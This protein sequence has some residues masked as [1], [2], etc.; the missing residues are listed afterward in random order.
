[1][2][3]LPQR[4]CSPIYSKYSAGRL[5]VS[6]S[7]PASPVLRWY[8]RRVGG[9]GPG[10]TSYSADAA[11]VV[12]RNAL[13]AGPRF[14][15]H[16]PALPVCSAW[17]G[18]RPGFTGPTA[19]GCVPP[20]QPE[21]RDG[22][23]H[24]RDTRGHRRGGHPRRRARRRRARPDRRAARRRGVPGHASWLRGLARLAARVRDRLPG[25]DRGDRQLRRRPGP[26][27]GD[28]W[29]PGRGG[30][31]LGPAGPAQSGRARGAP[32]GRDGQVEAI[33]ALMVAK[34]TARSERTQ[35]I[36]QARAL[37][38]TGPDDLRTRFS[39]HTPAGLVADL[40]ARAR[41][42]RAVPRQPA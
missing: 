12:L 26:A 38:L 15:W 4:T 10:L 27:H 23:D 17:P 9:L 1:M 33:R 40:A 22:I 20:L 8:G 6:A 7:G 31:P 37:V 28:G 24:R 25:R 5:W 39:R 3:V 35:T 2:C 19:S 11:G 16:P 34:R 42:A 30:G 18:Q 32:K 13:S 36:N 21:K 41:A 14:L 29:G